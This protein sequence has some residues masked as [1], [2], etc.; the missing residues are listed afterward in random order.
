MHFRIL[1]VDCTYKTNKYRLSLMEVVVVT[2]NELIFSIAFAYLQAEREDN[3]SWCL[4][5][6]KSLM[7]DWLISYFIVT[8]EN[9]ALM[10]ITERILSLSSF[11]MQMAYK[12]IYSYSMQKIF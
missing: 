3:F 11:L 1:I 6:H 7:H 10:N 12:K 9:L 4:N 2:S 5:S 8:D